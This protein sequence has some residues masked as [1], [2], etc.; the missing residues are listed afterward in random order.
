MIN[1]ILETWRE[2][3]DTMTSQ[4]NPTY[5]CKYCTKEYRKEST[6]AAHMCES[7]RRVQQ[8]KEV[9]VQ[10]GMQAYLR[11]YELTQGS[12]KMKT[13]T[14]FA[15]SSYYS[16]FVKFGRHMIAIR[17]VNPKMFI[18]WVIKE[19]KKLDHWCKE[20]IYA[21]FLAT[22]I[23]K[24]S[25]NDAV[26]R[27]LTEMQDYADETEGLQFKDYFRFGSTNRICSHITNGRISPWIVFNCDSGIK[28]LE[29]LN[30]E[31]IAI[32]MPWIDP[33]YWQRK[34]TDYMADTEW[35]KM[36]L[37]EASL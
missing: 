37:K 17:A 6:L 15:N 3:S 21:E 22:Y 9:G 18:E 5:K 25:I 33:E 26:E 36:I 4:S 24:E 29:T 23:K 16:A 11:F 12:A 19:N 13:Y 8:E 14:D 34:F 10:L 28:F 32:I 35:V 20:I 2:S 31:Q 7:K 30:E 1:E 27:A